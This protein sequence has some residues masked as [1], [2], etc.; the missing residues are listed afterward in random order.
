M[1]KTR[2]KKISSPTFITFAAMVS[3]MERKGL[4]T[5]GRKYVKFVSATPARTNQHR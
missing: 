2:I 4:P 1:P 3:P 5:T